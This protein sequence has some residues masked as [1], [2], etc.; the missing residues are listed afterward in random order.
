MSDQLVHYSL[1][2]SITDK[3]LAIILILIFLPIFLLIF[4]SMSIDMLLFPKNRGSF[5]Y[6]EKRITQGKEFEIL[7]FRIIKKEFVEEAH[8]KNICIREFEE[9]MTNLTFAGRFVLKKWYFDELAQLF[10]ILK[11]DMSLVGPRP[12]V[13]YLVNEQIDQG[14][15]FRKYIKAGWTSPG[16]VQYKGVEIKPGKNREDLDQEYVN[17]CRKWPVLKLWFYDFYVLY[18]TIIV[19][20]RGKGFIR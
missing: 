20:L 4:I 14:I 8:A 11:G 16:Q 12:L 17:N 15:V 6:K 3:L 1:L 2:K 5:F 9:N 13:P 18:L 10:N 19:M 7:K